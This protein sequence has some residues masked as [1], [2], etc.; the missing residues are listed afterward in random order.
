[1]PITPRLMPLLE[2]IMRPVIASTSEAVTVLESA[3]E[4]LFAP[5]TAKLSWKARKPGAP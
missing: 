4:I 3:D 1:M 5:S 2:G